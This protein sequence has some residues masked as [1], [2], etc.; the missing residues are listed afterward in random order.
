V[1][2][3]DH[4]PDCIAGDPTRLSQILI[5][6]LSRRAAFGRTNDWDVVLG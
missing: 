1:L 3:A 5:N 2:D 6:L 4:V